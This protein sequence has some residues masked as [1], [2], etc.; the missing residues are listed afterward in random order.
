MIEPTQEA[1][2]HDTSKSVSL[3]FG[4]LFV[5]VGDHIGH[6]Y[7]TPEEG[8]AILIPFLKAGLEA[9]D[10][11]VYMANPDPSGRDIRAALEAAQIDVE[12]A[13]AS[14]QLLLDVKMDSPE[15]LRKRLHTLIIKLPRRYRFLRWGGDMTWSLQQM[16]GSETLLE[17]EMMC[18]TLESPPVVFFCQYNLTQ[19]LGSVIIDA[20]KTHPL[21]IISNVIH[22]S[23]FYIPPVVFLE[24]LRRR[25]TPRA[26]S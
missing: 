5:S 6:F 12:R 24:E 20:F 14:G 21:C 17:W 25:Q 16:P 7:R 26:F 11:C 2:N 10:Q 15:E 22:R 1:T 18:N 4:D 9:G 19:L 23:P 13:L 3:G 8:E